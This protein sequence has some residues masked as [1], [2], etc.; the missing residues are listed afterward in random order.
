M[1][2]GGG[3]GGYSL[4]VAAASHLQASFSVT[5]WGLSSS[6]KLRAGHQQTQYFQLG[7]SDGDVRLQAE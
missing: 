3:P 4:L 7:S 1:G 2:G 5:S 6:C